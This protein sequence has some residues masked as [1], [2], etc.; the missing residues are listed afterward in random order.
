MILNYLQS[1]LYLIMNAF[2]YPVMALLL[3]FFIWILMLLGGFVSEWLLR[4]RIQSPEWLAAKLCNEIS[5]AAYNRASNQINAYL[6]GIRFGNLFWK[7]FL[8]ELAGEITEKREHLDLVLENLLQEYQ[9]KV[10]KM[11]D[12]TRILIRI[13]PMLGLM[14]TLIPMGPALLALSQG[15]LTRMANSLIIAFST[16]VVGLAI[17]GIAYV[18][19]TIRQRWYE[20]DIKDISYFSDLIIKNLNR[21]RL[22]GILKEKK[23]EK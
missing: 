14:G 10:E 18:I 23:K 6:E 17:G 2:L 22:N 3:V 21:V 16:T 19:S 12:K 15:D 1:A 20:E 5:H 13:G 8:G 9:I 7:N 11:V 4:K